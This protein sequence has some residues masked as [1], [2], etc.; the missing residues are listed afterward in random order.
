M[1]K[2]IDEEI[3]DLQEQIDKLEA[4]KKLLANPPQEYPKYISDLPAPAFVPPPKAG[5]IVN[6]AEEEKAVR[7]AAAKAAQPA[8]TEATTVKPAEA[9]RK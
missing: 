6:S 8:K 1:A 9:A 3:K 2:S 4:K 7:A 5:V